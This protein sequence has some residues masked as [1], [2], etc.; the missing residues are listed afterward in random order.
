MTATAAAIVAPVTYNVEIGK[1]KLAPEKF[2]LKAQLKLGEA[3]ILQQAKNWEKDRE[4]W[5]MQQER[6][7][8]LQEAEIMQQ[9]KDREA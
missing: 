2:K 5:N 4:A 1:E 9:E 3:K 6:E 7:M 8:K